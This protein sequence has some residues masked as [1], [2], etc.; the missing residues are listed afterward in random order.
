MGRGRGNE[1]ISEI[2]PLQGTLRC[3]PRPQCYVP[4]LMGKAE[5]RALSSYFLGWPCGRESTTW[6]GKLQV[7]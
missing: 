6:G 7:P 3:L 1:S 5:T 2:G 4:R